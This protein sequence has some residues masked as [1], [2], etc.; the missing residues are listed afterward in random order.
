MNILDVFKTW[1]I[2]ISHTIDRLLQPRLFSINPFHLI[3]SPRVMRV[4]NKAIIR[5][6]IAQQPGALP[7]HRPVPNPGCHIFLTK[8]YFISL[9]VNARVY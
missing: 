1:K 3:A 8:L 5:R 6:I 2:T 7:P 9:L 4:F